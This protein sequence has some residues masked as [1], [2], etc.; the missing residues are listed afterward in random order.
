MEEQT[1][2]VTI[3]I[4]GKN[5][6]YDDLTDN[7]KN[8]VQLYNKWNLE[9]QDSK[10]ETMKLEFALTVLSKQIAAEA[11]MMNDNQPKIEIR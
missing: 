5:Y 9:F 7:V 10:M 1:Q 2:K 11:S 8:L 3:S 6:N 4:D